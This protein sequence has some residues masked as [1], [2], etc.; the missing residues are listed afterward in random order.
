L[1]LEK[2]TEGEQITY[3]AVMKDD[4]QGTF[5]QVRVGADGSVKSKK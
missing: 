5:V 4:A 1:T 2:V 3:G